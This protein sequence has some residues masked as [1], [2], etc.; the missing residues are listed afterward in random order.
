M[1]LY[2]PS[3]LR[4]LALVAGSGAVPGPFPAF[5]VTPELVRWLSADGPVDD[6]ELEFAALAEAAR[7]SLRLLADERARDL[8]PVYRRVVVA[9]DVD[10]VQV[11]DDD[12]AVWPGSVRVDTDLRWSAVASVHL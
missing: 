11:V 7:G 12:P 8:H 1:R 3:T 6:E 10:G 5:A 2:I 4:D 9:A